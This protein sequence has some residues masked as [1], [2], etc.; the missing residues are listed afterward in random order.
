MF[1]DGMSVVDKDDYLE[2]RRYAIMALS[3]FCGMRAKEIR[4]SSVKDIIRDGDDWYFDVV[5]VKGERTY[6]KR[7][8]VPIPTEFHNHLT[9]YLEAREKYVQDRG[10]K[11][12][13]LFPS[14]TSESGELVSNTLRA[15]IARINR[16]LG[17]NFNLGDGGR[18]FG[19]KYLD[20]DAKIEDVS[21]L[22]GH[23]TTVTTEQFYCRRRNVRSLNAVKELKNVWDPNKR[24]EL[25]N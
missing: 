3:I 10:L 6:G 8:T 1:M 11:C 18:T 20:S 17:T 22:M 14:P 5:H 7:R 13:L 4:L 25:R 16:Q 23:N 9:L 15:D 2:L 19:Q 24:V 21:V 12:D